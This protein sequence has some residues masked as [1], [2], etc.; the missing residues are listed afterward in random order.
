MRPEFGCDINDLVF[1]VNNSAT[2]TMVGYHV[3]EALNRWEPR[4]NVVNVSVYAD[5][6][7][8]HKLNIEIEYEIKSSN[9]KANL[10]YPFY[11]EGEE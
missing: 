6:E 1:E 3:E 2:I 10:V 9:S 7:E 8:R 5:P 4:I 11:L